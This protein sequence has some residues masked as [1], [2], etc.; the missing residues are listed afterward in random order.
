MGLVCFVLA[1]V[2]FVVIVL[3]D[4]VLRLAV[5]AVLVGSD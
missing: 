4:F 1:F 2:M 3:E 5:V